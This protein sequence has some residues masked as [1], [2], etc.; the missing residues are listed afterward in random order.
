M[1]VVYVVHCLISKAHLIVGFF[2]FCGISLSPIIKGIKMH[3]QN[4]DII[5][6]RNPNT[7]EVV[8]LSVVIDGLRFTFYDESGRKFVEQ[9]E[10]HVVWIQEPLRNESGIPTEWE[11]LD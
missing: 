2:V 7:G 10:R 3:Y 11:I 8:N 1:T 6:A 9:G 5:K 4:G